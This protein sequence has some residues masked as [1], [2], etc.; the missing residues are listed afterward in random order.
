L[1]DILG[2]DRIVFTNELGIPVDV[3]V[4]F[5]ETGIRVRLTLSTSRAED[6]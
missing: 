1:A 4:A 5:E 6:K 3:T 2:I